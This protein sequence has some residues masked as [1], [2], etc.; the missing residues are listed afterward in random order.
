MQK[1]GAPLGKLSEGRSRALLKLMAMLTERQQFILNKVI[2]GHLELGRPVGSKW[3]SEQPDIRWSPSTIRYELAALEELGCLGH[4]HTS[5]GR[6][7][8]DA[9][10]RHYVDSLL[11]AGLSPPQP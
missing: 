2:E 3:L 9:G 5:A 1:S 6:V 8:T 11:E 7:P 10:Y 4:P